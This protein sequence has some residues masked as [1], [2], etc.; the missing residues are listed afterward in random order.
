MWICLYAPLVVLIIVV[1]VRNTLIQ[2]C[3]CGM[4][5]AFYYFT[6]GIEDQSELEDEKMDMMG[7]GEALMAPPSPDP[8]KISSRGY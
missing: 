4:N 6:I 1:A 5:K 3:C 2:N 8:P 7:D